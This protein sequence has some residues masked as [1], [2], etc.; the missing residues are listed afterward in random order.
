[1]PSREI[2]GSMSSSRT[3]RRRDR[4]Y[5][6]WKPVTQLHPAQD[7]STNVFDVQNRNVTRL[8]DPAFTFCHR[9]D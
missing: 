8:D 4:V 5:V 7:E 1:M 3:R 2:I 9:L 6:R